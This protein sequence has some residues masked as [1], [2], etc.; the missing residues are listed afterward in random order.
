MEVSV[1]YFCNKVFDF[2]LCLNFWISNQ[3]MSEMQ[4]GGGEYLC[5]WT[6]L[7]SIFN[8]HFALF[9]EK[10]YFNKTNLHL[11]PVVNN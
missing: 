8:R 6:S 10:L 5:C 11:R 3:P 1:T 4:I 2:Y 7:M 9:F